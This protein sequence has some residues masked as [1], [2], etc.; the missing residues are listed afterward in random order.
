MVRVAG[1]MGQA[2]AGISA[3][4]A[5]GLSP[6]LQLEAINKRAKILLERQHDCWRTL[7]RE[8]A[9]EDI[10][11]LETSELGEADKEWLHG[12]FRDQIYPVLTPIAVDP[13]HPFPFI[14]NLGLSM[15]VELRNLE[16][17][18]QLNGL[19]PLPSQL[20]RFIRLSGE[21]LR[22]LRLEHLVRL[23]LDELFPGFEVLGLGIFRVLR[24][25]DIEIEEEAEDLVQ[26]F[27]SALRRRRRGEVIRLTVDAEMPSSLR[28][29]VA[30]GTLGACR[31]LSTDHPRSPGPSIRALRAPVSR[32]RP[33][34]QRGLLCCHPS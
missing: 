24:D 17:G 22:F 29:F 3:A 13:A 15:V 23:F 27:K 9:E 10:H 26:V 32:T 1:L 18:A 16:D 2:N 8:L 12:Y 11:V 34:F 21:D 25:S 31:H 5:D 28:E 4:S 6:A 20:G 33:R 19:I 30:E 14:P 7:R